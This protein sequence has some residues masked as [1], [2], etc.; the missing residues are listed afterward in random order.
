MNKAGG[1]ES[2]ERIREE[3]EYWKSSKK[4]IQIDDIAI[5]KIQQQHI[6]SVAILNEYMKDENEENETVRTETKSETLAGSIELSQIQL[7]ALS[8]FDKN[9]FSVSH[10]DMEAF[11]RSNSLMK[12][13][14]VE[15]INEFC[16][17]LLDD[18]LIEENDEYYTVNPC[19]YQKILTN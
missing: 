11:A 13:Q 3:Q 14:L 18:V 16:Y 1:K 10:S 9:D 19:Y 8:L 5:A 2:A 7:S 17:E 12:N 6:E 15:S 4:R